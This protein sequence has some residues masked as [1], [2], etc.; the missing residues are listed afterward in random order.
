M[1]S[2]SLPPHIV[3]ALSTPSQRSWEMIAEWLSYDRAD[4]A[5]LRQLKQHLVTWPKEIPR[6]PPK[7]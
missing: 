2:P 5:T 6:Q 4:A 1:T 7:Q 3:A